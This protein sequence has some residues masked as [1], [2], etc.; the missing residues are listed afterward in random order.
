MAR[1]VPTSRLTVFGARL[2]LEAGLS[3]PA[4][5]ASVEVRD[6]ALAE[7]GQEVTEVRLLDQV[8]LRRQC[9]LLQFEP[10]I[11]RRLQRLRGLALPQSVRPLFE[12]ASVLELGS[13]GQ[14]LRRRFRRLLEE[15]IPEFEVVR[16]DCRAAATRQAVPTRGVRRR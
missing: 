14:F 7:D 1:K 3:V 16:P 6:E 11:G 4:D 8:V 13:S 15:P 5:V 10:G 9:R 2:L 12:V